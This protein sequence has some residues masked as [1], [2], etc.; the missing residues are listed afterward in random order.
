VVQ[1]AAVKLHK[2]Q[3]VEGSEFNVFIRTER[4]IPAM[5][6]DLKNPLVEE[7]QQHTLLE[8]AEAMQRFVDY[9]EGCVLLGHNSSYDY[10]IMDNNMRRRCGRDDFRE[11]FPRCLD[12]LH[13][14][15][16]IN[17]RLRSH[18]LRDLIEEFGLEGE[19]SHLAN[20]DILATWHL[21]EYCFREGMT[22]AAGQMDLPIKYSRATKR[23][24]E[25]YKPLYDHTRALLY[26]QWDGDEPALLAEW[27]YVYGMLTSMDRV[28][29]IKKMDYVERYLTDEV[30]G[31]DRS[32][33]HVQLEQHMN[34]LNTLK[35]ADLCGSRS[36]SERVFVST[37]H[38]AK[39]L[40]FDNVI[41]YEVSD[42]NYPG[43]FARDDVQRQQEEA[44]RL[45]V[46]LTR[47]KQRLIL[48]W[49]SKRITQ[50][51]RVFEQKL[52]PFVACITKFFQ[53]I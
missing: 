39:G 16:I 35:E 45:Y 13:M 50:W 46:A 52:S 19:N 30:I 28:E 49:S 37:V 48:M 40:E 8:P 22:K 53:K 5:L 47:A 31:D 2:G 17:P 23:L 18:K 41:V 20:D 14:A 3:F 27:R 34:M 6:G 21:A 12:T 24:R 38:K 9:A 36:M 11:R 7:Y 51:G 42:G 43:F 4:E 32:P 26:E 29:P 15:R 10:H 1:I 44:R 25:T 33:L